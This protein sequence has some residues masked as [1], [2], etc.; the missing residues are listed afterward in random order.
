MSHLIK[1]L[2]KFF[3]VAIAASMVLGIST[4][5]LAEQKTPPILIIDWLIQEPVS[6]MDRGIDKLNNEVAL[7]AKNIK[8]SPP[9]GTAPRVATGGAGYDLEKNKILIGLSLYYD[10]KKSDTISKDNCKN[11]L[12]DYLGKPFF[13]S[14]KGMLENKLYSV[15]THAVGVANSPPEKLRKM[16]PDL[17]VFFVTIYTYPDT[18]DFNPKQTVTCTASSVENGDIP[19][20]RYTISEGGKS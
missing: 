17:V 1:K 3:C 10:K 8:D 2:C 4:S 15:F 7:I 11:I 19:P 5:S 12:L 13:I 14:H 9:R 18:L 6:L 16:L 20:I